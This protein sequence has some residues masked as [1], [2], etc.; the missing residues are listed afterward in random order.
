MMNNK[1]FLKSIGME[2]RIA[3]I[4]KNMSQ[5]QVS[6]IAGLHVMTISEI[7]TGKSDGH[8]L[9]YKRIADALGVA[10]KHIL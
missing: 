4:R 7:E 2:L 5:G 10:L 9:N 6:K 3:R 1:E 8:I